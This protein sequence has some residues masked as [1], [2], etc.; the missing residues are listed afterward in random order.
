MKIKQYLKLDENAVSPVIGVILLVAITV[1]M[2]TVIGAYSLGFSDKLSH[3][4]DMA[5]FTDGITGN[6]TDYAANTTGTNT[7]GTNTTDGNETTLYDVGVTVDFL[8]VGTIIV[9]VS[10]GTDLIE[11]D[12]MTVDINNVEFFSIDAGP[13]AIPE[14][15]MTVN[16]QFEN[17]APAFEQP[18]SV[19]ALAM[20]YDRTADYVIGDEGTNH[21]VITATFTDGTTQTVYDAT[22]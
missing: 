21:V 11:I 19:D 4:C 10:G 13:D 1:M 9:T 22:V 2:S 17:Q 7:T 18:I 3:S 16:W 14:A 15:A 5:S 20:C 12:T 8:N 6:T